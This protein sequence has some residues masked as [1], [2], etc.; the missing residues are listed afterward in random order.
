MEA[1]STTDGQSNGKSAGHYHAIG[2]TAA[3]RAMRI[4]SGVLVYWK[5]D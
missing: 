1:A 5:L 3:E 2:A 4:K